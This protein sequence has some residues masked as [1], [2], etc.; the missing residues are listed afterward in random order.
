MSNGSFEASEGA[1][2]QDRVHQL[3][4][5]SQDAINHSS[6]QKNMKFIFR[7]L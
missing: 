6:Y 2:S 7:E 5:A 4:G 3:E 1:I